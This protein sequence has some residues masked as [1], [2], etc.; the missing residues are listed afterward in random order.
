MNRR[1]SGDDLPRLTRS[2]PVLGPEEA[3]R[4]LISGAIPRDKLPSLIEVVFSD[5]KA[6]DMVGC[7]RGSDVQAFIDA[8]YRV[9]Y[10]LP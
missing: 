1:S 4:C 8:I 9:C 2:P 7:L 6:T 10:V 3:L 5:E